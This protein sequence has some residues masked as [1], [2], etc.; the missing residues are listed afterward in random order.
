M[1]RLGSAIMAA[2]VEYE[3]GLTTSSSIFLLSIE[4]RPLFA[5]SRGIL[6]DHVLAVSTQS[7]RFNLLS[8]FVQ[9]AGQECLK[10]FKCL[11]NMKGGVLFHNL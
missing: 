2:F 4:V 1:L 8:V 3:L 11:E 5:T 9:F 7:Y 6:C 10:F